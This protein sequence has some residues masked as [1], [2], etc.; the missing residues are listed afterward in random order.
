MGLDDLR[1][2]HKRR[3]SFALQLVV[4]PKHQRKEYPLISFFNPSD[5]GNSRISLAADLDVAGVGF[6]A[7]WVGFRLG[8]GHRFRRRRD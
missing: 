6:K 5:L 2:G 3:L 4:P 1:C 7:C 8:P